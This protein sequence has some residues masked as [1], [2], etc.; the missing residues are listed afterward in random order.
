LIAE[1]HA[2]ARVVREKKCH[3]ISRA[4][5]FCQRQKQ[6]HERDG[7]WV[8][9]NTQYNAL[10]KYRTLTILTFLLLHVYVCGLLELLSILYDLQENTRQKESRA[11]ESLLDCMQK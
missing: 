10:Y 9:S 4:A 1:E 2:R 7:K 8:S 3:N 11:A 6:T 5:A